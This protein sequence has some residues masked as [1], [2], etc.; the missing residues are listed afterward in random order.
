MHKILP[1]KNISDICVVAVIYNG[2]VRG[3][4]CIVYDAP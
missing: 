3:I 1:F 4:I 2:S